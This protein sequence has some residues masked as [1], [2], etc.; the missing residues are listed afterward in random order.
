MK[1][2]GKKW[3][4]RKGWKAMNERKKILAISET[5]P[6]QSMLLPFCGSQPMMLR[7]AL[8]GVEPQQYITLNYVCS[9]QGQTKSG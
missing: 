3:E 6:S 4:L 8:K 9:S 5:A 2:E 1:E 7:R